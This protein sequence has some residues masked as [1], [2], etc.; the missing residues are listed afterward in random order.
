M[1]IAP[2]IGLVAWS[3]T[4]AIATPKTPWDYPLDGAVLFAVSLV[5]SIVDRRRG[6]LAAIPLMLSQAILGTS[7]APIPTGDPNLWVGG[8][9]SFLFIGVMLAGVLRLLEIVIDILFGPPAGPRAGC[10]Q[11]CGYNLTGNV[12]GVCPECGQKVDPAP[13]E[14]FPTE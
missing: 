14:S 5:L 3:I 13:V 9:L 2:V 8:L 10:C 12:S 7:F 1:G 4:T 6:W 11:H